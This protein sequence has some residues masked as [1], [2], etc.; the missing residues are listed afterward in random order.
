M[1]R[2]QRRTPRSRTT[3]LLSTDGVIKLRSGA[4]DIVTQTVLDVPNAMDEA[5]RKLATVIFSALN[6]FLWN[7]PLYCFKVE[8]GHNG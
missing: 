8:E 7:R 3:G 4:A 6:T 1:E 2:R 5:P